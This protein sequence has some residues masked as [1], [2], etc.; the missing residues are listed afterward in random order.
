MYNETKISVNN[1]Y[2]KIGF[3][4]ESLCLPKVNIESIFVFVCREQAYEMTG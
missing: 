3:Y 4:G 2:G 1:V